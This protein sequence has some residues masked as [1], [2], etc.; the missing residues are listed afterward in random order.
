[1]GKPLTSVGAGHS[2]AA[3]GVRPSNALADVKGLFSLRMGL[4]PAI[5]RTRCAWS[6]C[7][8]G[9]NVNGAGLEKDDNGAA[10]DQPDGA[11]GTDRWKDAGDAARWKDAGDAAR[12]KDAGDAGGCGELWGGAGVC[13]VG[14]DGGPRQLGEAAGTERKNDAGDFG[15]GATTAGAMSG[16]DRLT[17]ASP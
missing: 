6:T 9:E 8:E 2:N 5:V 7:T 1:M 15:I 17:V 13:G 12:R 10:G 16:T 14:I 3:T 11:A 4:A